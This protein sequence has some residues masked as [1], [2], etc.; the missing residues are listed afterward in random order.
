MKTLEF[1]V[2]AVWDADAGVY[3]SESDI[4]GLHVEAA[5]LEEFE[6][7]AAEL[8]PQLIVENHISKRDLAQRSLSELIPWIKFR[9]PQTGG[10]AAA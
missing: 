5:S 7:A 2:K 3:Y 1:Y 8:G 6:A 10:A 9:A 4:I